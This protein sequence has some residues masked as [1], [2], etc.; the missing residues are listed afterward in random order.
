[1]LNFREAFLPG[2]IM[3]ESE[4]YLTAGTTLR[5][6]LL[7]KDHKRI[8]ILYMLAIT[9]FFLIGGIAAVVFRIEL[10]TPQGDFVTA[11][12]YN[13]MFSLHGIIMVWFFL[14]PAAP[15]VLGNFFVPM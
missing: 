14:L 1:M 15:V 10:A 7:T 3:S 5:S 9:F 6:W 4:N 12:T 11:D 2:S 8:A 13:K